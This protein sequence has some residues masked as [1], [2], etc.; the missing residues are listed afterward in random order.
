MLSPPPEIWFTFNFWSCRSLNSI[1]EL[2][3]FGLNLNCKFNCSMVTQNRHPFGYDILE[4]L[5]SPTACRSNLLLILIIIIG[6]HF[7]SFHWINSPS[8]TPAEHFKIFHLCSRFDKSSTTGQM[9]WWAS[10]GRVNG[11]RKEGMRFTCGIKNSIHLIA[12]PET[13][14]FTCNL[15]LGITHYFGGKATNNSNQHSR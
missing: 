3:I 10:T 13:G 8:F 9:G 15:S 2:P 14:D 7:T 12:S 4:L 6:N 1:E 11:V 5:T